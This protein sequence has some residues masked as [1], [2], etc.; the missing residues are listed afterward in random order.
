VLEDILMN[1]KNPMKN[2][3]LVSDKTIRID[4][5]YERIAPVIRDARATVMR[6]IDTVMV[7]AYWKIGQQIVEEEQQGATRA[8]YGK[9]VLSQLSKRLTQEFGRGFGITTL[10]DI[11]KFYLVYQR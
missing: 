4:I 2:N 3:S 11:R 7:H 1:K 9:E 10:E 6:T 5:L 8:D